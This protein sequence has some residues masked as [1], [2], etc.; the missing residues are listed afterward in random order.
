MN[1]PSPIDS[2]TAD[3]TEKEIDRA[4]DAAE[5]NAMQRETVRNAGLL[6]EID[7]LIQDELLFTERD[8]FTARNEALPKLLAIVERETAQWRDTAALA[9]GKLAEAERKLGI[10]TEALEFAREEFGAVNWH[11]VKQD[12]HGVGETA[13]KGVNMTHD[14]LS[15]L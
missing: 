3:N 12:V 8:W 1:I 4:I 15:R 11:L 7:C 10:A 6:E 9:T 2:L 14:A 5:T 13:R